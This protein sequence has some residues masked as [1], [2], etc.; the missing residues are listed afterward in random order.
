[1]KRSAGLFFAV[2]VIVSISAGHMFLNQELPATSNTWFSASGLCVLCH[3][4]S[5]FALRDSRGNDVSPVNRWRSTMLA[6][7]SKDPFWKAKVKHEGIMNPSHRD[8][9]ENVCTKCHAPM[10]MLNA[11]LTASGI[12]TLDLLKMDDAGKDGIS[13]TLC[14]QINDFSSSLFSGNFGINASKEIYGPY[15][16]PIAN[17]MVMNT[18]YTPVYSEK[19]NDSR[20]CGSCHTLLTNS[21]DEDGEPTGQTFV[22]QALYHEWENSVYS[23]QNISCQSCH[24][25]RIYEPVKIT[26]R[27]GFAP[28]REPF[29]IH[30][31][32]GG[33]FF[34]LTLLK[35]NHGE[36]QLHSGVEFLA[37]SAERTQNM[38]T[39]KTV[40]LD[41]RE[42]NSTNDSLFFEVIL[43]NKAGHKFPTGFPSRRAYLEYLIIQDSDTLF[44]SG[45]PGSAALNNTDREKFEPHYQ[46]INN[47]NQVQ[48]YEFVMGDTKGKVTTIL[49]K[50]FVP[51]KDNRIVPAGF[52]H[53]HTN[54]DTVKIVGRAIND[55]DYINGAGVESVIYSFPRSAI[56]S[57]AKVK[58]SLFYETSP[59]SWLN[60]LFEKADVDEDISRYKNMYYKAN[61]NPVLIAADSLSTAATFFPEIKKE[62]IH[63]YPNPA[64]GRI[65]IDGADSYFNY[66]LFNSGG[67]CVKD[68]SVV[69]NNTEIWLDLPSGNYFLVLHGPNG[70]EVSHTIILKK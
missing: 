24:I 58:V 47:E 11:H 10:G 68:G 5:D 56:S 48:I 13:C 49:E 34:M 15:P 44:H 51:L 3:S 60:E 64:T 16:S 7:A 70:R 4:T 33:N 17:Q 67:I 42:K 69:G 35:E 61:R 46:K 55:P 38:L 20:L 53:S 26:S 54:Y 12:Y 22:E 14:H 62:N 8:A 43:K 23:E 63:I 31:F 57:S 37:Q 50:A 36:L 27:P 21:V 40:D 1:M 29:G 41:V 30:D 2:I 25:P 45:K 52:Q 19:I 65:F 59:E 9:L 6:N 32:T 66:T 39:E 28:G 18:G